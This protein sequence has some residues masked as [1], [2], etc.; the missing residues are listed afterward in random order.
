VHKKDER[1][2]FAVLHFAG[3]VKYKVREWV[4]KN[5]DP[6]PEAMATT[7]AAVTKTSLPT[8]PELA[9]ALAASTGDGSA[10]ASSS[11]GSERRRSS[12]GSGK[13][14][15]ARTVCTSFVASMKALTTQLGATKCNFIR[16]VKPNPSMAYGV[17]DR[18]YV[19]EQLR[20]LGVLTTC[21]VLKA[22][23][24][25]RITYK[26]LQATALA[27]LPTETRALFDGQPEEVLIAAC[28][29]AFDVP[30]DGYQLGRTRVFFK[31][32]ICVYVC[33]YMLCCDSIGLFTSSE[34]FPFGFKS[35]QYLSFSFVYVYFNHIRFSAHFSR[36]TQAGEISR[37][38]SILKSGMTP[39]VDA[40]IKDALARRA[41]A[42]EAA[43]VR[44]MID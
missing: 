1:D 36:C 18:R 6:L 25:T 37:V 42:L 13:G 21:E 39:E 43:Q 33:T 9:A 40:K 3:S 44:L 2:C 29:S 41:R 31:V 8:M 10:A 7:F 27:G 20:C 17:V 14:G 28:L 32:M 5:S 16:C 15:G 35:V 30:P 24:P 22:G 11:S 19:V 23:L 12:T 38:E 26:E 34:V 4:L